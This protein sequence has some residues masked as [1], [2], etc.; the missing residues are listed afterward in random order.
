MTQPSPSAASASSDKPA[1]TIEIN[2]ETC[3]G[4]G[5][6]VVRAPAIFA[7]DDEGLAVVAVPQDRPSEALVEAIEVCPTQSIAFTPS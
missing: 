3:I 6:C 4:S 2:R 7:I 1:M 5:Q